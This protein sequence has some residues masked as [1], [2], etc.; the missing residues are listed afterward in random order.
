MRRTRIKPISNKK[1][2]EFPA[3]AE[4]RRIVIE[5]DKVCQFLLHVP[6]EWWARPIISALPVECTASQ[7][8]HEPARRANCDYLDPSECVLLCGRHHAWVGANIDLAREMGLYVD[9]VGRTPS[10]SRL[11]TD[12]DLS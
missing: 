1:R 11:L 9:A 12:F 2:A 4:C 3:R 6:E 7:E 10:K 5:R 8:V